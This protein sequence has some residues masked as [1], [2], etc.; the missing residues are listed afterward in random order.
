MNTRFVKIF[1]SSAVYDQDEDGIDLK[2]GVR[3]KDRVRDQA[4]VFTRPREVN[5]M[6]DLIKPGP[7][8]VTVSHLEPSCGDGAFLIEII[9]RKLAWI[10]EHDDKDP[11]RVAAAAVVALSTTCGVDISVRNVMDA[12]AR[13]LE[14]VA[15]Y[16]PEGPW[17]D[18]GEAVISSNIVVGDFLKAFGTDISKKKVKGHSPRFVPE[19]DAR[20]SEVV[21]FVRIG[22]SRSKDMILSTSTLGR[23]SEILDAFS[24]PEDLTEQILNLAECDE[25]EMLGQPDK[26]EKVGR[27]GTVSDAALD[28]LW[29][30]IMGHDGG[31]A[32]VLSTANL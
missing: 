8:E 5:A 14:A 15:P 25:S 4:E 31:K 10:D 16:L 6:L 9:R 17:R 23:E 13:I 11:C 24:T 3:S 12:Q 30:A 21:R 1:T 32:R 2:N 19:P 28:R 20:F 18:L 26:V 22:I 29:C 7:I 27:V